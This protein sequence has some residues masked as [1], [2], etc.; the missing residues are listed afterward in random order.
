DLAFIPADAE[1]VVRVD[2]AQVGAR[3]PA[4]QKSLKT[5]DFLLHAQQPAAWQVLHAA[6]ITP[7]RE[8]ATVYLVAAKDA[9]LLAGLGAFDQARLADALKK[10][11]GAPEPVPGAL[12]FRWRGAKDQLAGLSDGIVL[13]GDPDLVR[14]ALAVR[15]GRGPD[16]RKAPLAAELGA[17]DPAA[18]VGGAAL[19]GHEGSLAGL[20]PG[21][22]RAHFHAALAAAGPGPD[23]L[24]AL[25]AEFGSPEQ[26]KAFAKELRSIFDTVSMLGAS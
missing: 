15:S 12:L 20:L 3:S 8:L 16:V 1:A 9:I 21:C 7:G 24:L 13:L 5:L 19:P 26:A 17:V 18:T 25:R 23:G 22:T 10:A 11:G 2:L 6:G 14:L 4:P